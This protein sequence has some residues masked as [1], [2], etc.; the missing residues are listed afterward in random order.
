MNSVTPPALSFSPLLLFCYQPFC[1]EFLFTISVSPKIMRS[2]R[3]RSVL[4]SA[5]SLALR[6]VC[7][8]GRR[9]WLSQRTSTPAGTAPFFFHQALGVIISWQ[10]SILHGHL[11]AQPWVALRSHSQHRKSRENKEELSRWN[12]VLFHTALLLRGRRELILSQK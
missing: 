9:F 7:G 6:T 5:L 11:A 4:F 10:A 12:T 8:T 1:A 3:G 2:E